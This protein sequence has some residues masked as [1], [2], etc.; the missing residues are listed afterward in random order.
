MVGTLIDSKTKI[1]EAMVIIKQLTFLK[2][3]KFNLRKTDEEQSLV[4]SIFRPLGKQHVIRRQPIK[5]YRRKWFLKD[6]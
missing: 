2:Y 6:K 5:K 3:Q 1:S 4:L